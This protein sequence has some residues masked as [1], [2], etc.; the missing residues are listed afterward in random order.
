M[1]Y[2]GK[3]LGAIMMI[4]LGGGF[5]PIVLGLII[6]HIVDKMQRDQILG[7]GYFFDQQTR[8]NVFLRTTFQVMGYVTKSK[9]RVTEADIMNANRLMTW[10]QLNHVLKSAAQEAF[11]EGKKKDFPL[12][13]R[14]REFRQICLGH[15]D[16][17]RMFLEIQ[18]QAAL[19]DGWLHDNERQVLYTIAKE[20]GVTHE[21]F[22]QFLDMM[23]VDAQFS[24]QNNYFEDCYRQP[25]RTKV[26]TVEDACNVLGVNPQDD[27]Q[28]IK[29]AYRKLMRKHHPDKLVAKDLPS[30]MMEIA[31]RKTQA[32]QQAYDFLKRE[33][34]FR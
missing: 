13:S 32:I 20:L 9:G 28:T 34:G 6:G 27:S 7:S 10:M 24:A 30:E 1:R 12:R 26:P 11:R 19:A 17:I 8:Q 22:D 3:L 23:K 21:Q 25:S 31:K 33:K 15:F 5:W 14:L 18:I 4:L 29:R 2:W 16:L